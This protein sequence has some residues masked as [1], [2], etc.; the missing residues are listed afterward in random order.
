VPKDFNFRTVKVDHTKE[1]E[2]KIREDEQ[3]APWLAAE[4][5]EPRTLAHT[6]PLVTQCRLCCARYISFGSGAFAA[7][8]LARTN[9]RIFDALDRETLGGDR[10]TPATKPWERL[11]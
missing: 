1:I 7:A 5:T 8:W 9:A 2:S 6:K 3:A 4:C 11:M 10:A